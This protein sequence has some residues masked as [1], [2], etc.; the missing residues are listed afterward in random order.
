MKGNNDKYYAWE[1][2][3]AAVRALATSDGPW[4]RRLDNAYGEFHAAGEDDMPDEETKSIYR[5]LI[6]RLTWAED[7]T[8]KGTLPATLDKIS[9]TEAR[10][11]ASLIKDIESSLAHAIIDAQRKG[12][13]WG[14]HH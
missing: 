5:Q 10:G 6:A 14:T 3:G 9:D 1:K 4:S 12:E 8:G 11:I 13:Q 7:T 2:F